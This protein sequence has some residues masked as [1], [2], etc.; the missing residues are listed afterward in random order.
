MRISDFLNDFANG[1]IDPMTEVPNQS[2]ITRIVNIFYQ[3]E[4]KELS[5]IDIITFSPPY[6]QRMRGKKYDLIVIDECFEM[7]LDDQARLL[8]EMS[9]RNHSFHSYHN[10]RLYNRHSSFVQHCFNLSLV[11]RYIRLS[12]VLMPSRTTTSTSG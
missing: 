12:S 9:Y 2:E 8:E 7:H 6:L 3:K 4:Y 5:K 1:K 10:R 11:L